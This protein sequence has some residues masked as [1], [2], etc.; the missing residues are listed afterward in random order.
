MTE[1]TITCDRCKTVVTVVPTGLV[2]LRS[3]AS[4][5][6]RPV[7]LCGECEREFDR[8]LGPATGQGGGAP[9]EERP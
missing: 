9:W 7:D 6:R 2:E 1:I 5:R 4:R 8:W 3:G